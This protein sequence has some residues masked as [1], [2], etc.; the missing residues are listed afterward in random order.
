[1]LWG[2][3]A[4]ILYQAAIESAL[5][6]ALQHLSFFGSALLFWWAL[7]YGRLGRLGYG[8]A[9]LA[10]FPTA[11]HSSVLGALLTASPSPWYQSYLTTTEA[12]NLTPLE[13]QQLA[14][15]IMW[16]PA[17]MIYLVG[18]LALFASWLGETERRVV[19]REV[20]GLAFRR[21]RW[22]SDI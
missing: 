13:D 12:W 22:R 10:A 8:V 4:P 19:Q 17:G 20:Q 15:L 11:V 2:W 18:A 1:V 6:H 5:V 16:V 3:H 7:L 14:G 9:V 21:D